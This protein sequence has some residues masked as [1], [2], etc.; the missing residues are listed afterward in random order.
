MHIEVIVCTECFLLDAGFSSF[1]PLRF[2]LP[3]Q[4]QQVLRGCLEDQI[5]FSMVAT[6]RVQLQLL[7]SA[8]EGNSG[9]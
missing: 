1:S 8:K 7:I 9:M 2:S 6:L 3:R 5:L 4:P